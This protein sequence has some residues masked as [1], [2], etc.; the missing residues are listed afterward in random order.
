MRIAQV[1]TVSAPVRE[2]TNGSIES[3]VWLLARELGRR[4]HE[5][6]VFGIA[7]SAV[8]GEL[9][10]TLPGP[11]ASPGVPEDWQVC[12]WVNLCRAVEQ[13][14]RFDVLHCHAYLWGLP[15]QPFSRAP[16]VHTLHIVPDDTAARLWGLWPAAHVTAISRHQWSAYPQLRPA[17]IIPHGVDIAHFTLR[18][19]PEDYVLFLGRFTPG[20]GVRQAIA[21]A[22]SLGLRIVLAGPEN[23]YYREHVRPLVDGH[24]VQYAGF[25]SGAERD[26]LLGGARA[27]VYPIQFP[28]SFGL[29]LVEAMLC[30][31]PVAAIRLGAVPEVVDEGVTGHLADSG[32]TFPAALQSCLALD[33]RAVRAQAERRFAAA[34]M[35]DAYARLYE[36]IACRR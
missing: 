11:Y 17:A 9:V 34:T 18:E 4:G 31:T 24:A 35:A 13:S 27:L 22:R 19:Q 33:R 20:K 14:G 3:L 32:E 21:A 36:S 30:G 15:L 25:V 16:L 5:V 2:H 10:A 7:G 1:A 23:P 26:R 28:E 6:T 8:E 29:V 12:E